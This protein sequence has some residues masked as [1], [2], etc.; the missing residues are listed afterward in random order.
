MSHGTLDV[1]TDERVTTIT[2]NR[3]Y[4]KNALTL[5]MYRALRVSPPASVGTRPTGVTGIQGPTRWSADGS[6][7]QPCR[8]GACT[9]SASRC[10]ADPRWKRCS[11]GAGWSG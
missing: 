5:D 11:V 9:S 10:E 4:K 2:L 8:G 6:S 7:P 3:L 1:T